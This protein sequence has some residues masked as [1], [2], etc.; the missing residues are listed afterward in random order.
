M[1][2]FKRVY[3]RIKAGYIWGKGMPE[4]K[5][6]MFRQEL[7]Q[8]F[9]P[10]N[11]ALKKK[12]IASAS[13]E[14]IR[15]NEYLYCHPMS[16]SGA[17]FE[18]TIKELTEKLKKVKSFELKQV[19][20]YND[21]Y[22]YEEKELKSVLNSQKE[23]IQA[24]LINAYKTKR[25]DSYKG[26]DIFLNI[27]HKITDNMQCFNFQK[28]I[29]EKFVNNIFSDLIRQNKIIKTKKGNIPVFQTIKN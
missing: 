26:Y 13:D 18:E 15:D 4:D 9:T 5:N 10:M 1:R 2:T 25:K 17:L 19:D 29:I 24:K 22:L 27:L 6:E 11:F 20:V 8:I 12:T 16:L 7:S 28:V 3:F 23:K 21:I 14:Y